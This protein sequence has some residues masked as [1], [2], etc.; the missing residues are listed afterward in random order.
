MAASLTKILVILGPTAS[1]KSELALTLAEHIGGT[2][3]EIL[4]VDSMQVYRHMDIGT[5]KPT[6]GEQ[7]RVRHHLIDFVEPNQEFTVARF[8]ELADATIRDARERGV[9]LIANGGTPLY[10]KA[11]FE[12]MFEGPGASAE[13]RDRLR[14]LSNDE[15]H[16]RLTTVDPAAAARIH[17]ND[18][19]RLIRALEVH[20]LTG[21]PISSLQREWAEPTAR[22]DA[23][24]IGLDWDKDALNRRINSRVKSM[25]EA[26][27][28]DETR[29]LLDRFGTLSKTAGE[30]T[31]YRELIDHLA[32]RSSLDDAIEQI[33]IATRQ[34]ARRQMKWFRRFR[35][36]HWISGNLPLE[37]KV[38]AVLKILGK[39]TEP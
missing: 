26:G 30:A 34:L 22:H 6:P 10:Y 31:G 25:I 32:G 19:K 11:L 18:T 21:E 17:R 39:P 7:R 13:I 33:K 23:V 16:A 28:I 15:L 29:R 3:G 38:A 20:E 8:V 27:W 1:G 5:A 4:S 2:R 14:A 9:A 35:H 12:G 36:V 37:E 24:W